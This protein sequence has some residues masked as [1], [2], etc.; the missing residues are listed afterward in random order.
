MSKT[1]DWFALFN[2]GNSYISFLFDAANKGLTTLT[3]VADDIVLFI[4]NIRCKWNIFTI[5]SHDI[6]NCRL[7]LNCFK[8]S[9]DDGSLARDGDSTGAFQFN[10]VFQ[11]VNVQCDTILMVWRKGAGHTI[12]P[13]VY[14]AVSVVNTSAFCSWRLND[15]QSVG[16][17]KT[18][19][20]ERQP[21]AM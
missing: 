3:Y 16:I 4:I 9:K 2:P 21:A 1:T 19:I 6:H 15:S 5:A 17:T 12:T 20:T 10:I 11:I 8:I 18:V 13:A 7:S 14:G